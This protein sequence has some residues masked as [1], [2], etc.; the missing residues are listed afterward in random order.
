[1]KKILVVQSIHE[2]GIEL[3]KSNTTRN[4]NDFD[5][6]LDLDSKFKMLL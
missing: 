1:M 3:L 2:A 6:K 5:L 4:K